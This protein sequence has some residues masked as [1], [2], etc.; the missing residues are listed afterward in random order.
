MGAGIALLL[1][2]IGGEMLIHRARQ[3]PTSESTFSPPA[4]STPS[5]PPTSPGAQPSTATLASPSSTEKPNPEGGQNPAPAATVAESGASSE[6]KKKPARGMSVVPP[7]SRAP[8]KE[9]TP[10]P[11]V[12]ESASAHAA[13]SAK[14]VQLSCSFELQKAALTVSNDDRIFFQGTLIGR[15]KSGLLHLKG[16]YAGVFSRPITI[17][18]GTRDLS[19]QVVSSDGAL[20]LKKNISVGPQTY[21]P[22][23]LQIEVKAGRLSVRWV[24]TPSH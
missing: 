5:P 24:E 21:A 10:A 15:K 23:T 7:T 9:P 11:S 3:K 4:S 17:P 13:A 18:A 19:V 12:A 2:L 22:V 8:R 14:V 1:A 20:D 6:L 16:G